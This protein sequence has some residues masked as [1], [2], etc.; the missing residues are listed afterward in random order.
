MKYVLS[1]FTLFFAYIILA[2]APDKDIETVV[3]GPQIKFLESKYDFGEVTQGDKVQHDFLYT[4][5][6]SDPL[7][8]SDVRT[9]CGCTAPNW[10]REALAP[11]DTTQLKVVFNSV[12]KR[13]MQA[14]VITVYSNAINNP[15][16]VT[17][18]GNV[19]MPASNEQ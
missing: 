18:T 7:V 9:T 14:K 19:L 3:D 16:R 17:L 12:G 11:G 4:N 13:G 1:I 10:S 6:G 8:I 2:Q 15:E 5:I